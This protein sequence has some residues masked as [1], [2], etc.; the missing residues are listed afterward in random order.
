MSIAYQKY[1]LEK[2]RYK[3][4]KQIKLGQKNWFKF[5][6]IGKKIFVAQ[7]ILKYTK[8]VERVKEQNNTI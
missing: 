2:L 7:I 4:V 8:S 5:T 6:L 1:G 3:E